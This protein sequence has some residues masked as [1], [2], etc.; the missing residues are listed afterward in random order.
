MN[1]KENILKLNARGGE[2]IVLDN[3]LNE[4]LNQLIEKEVYSDNINVL[5]H[6][7]VSNL[8]NSSE[9]LME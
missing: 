3:D 6:S 7:L 4:L 1:I 5:R 8:V 2:P 9:L